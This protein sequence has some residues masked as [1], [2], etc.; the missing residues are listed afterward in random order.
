[1]KKSGSFID[2]SN[3]DTFDLLNNQITI[4]QG[5][6]QFSDL[7]HDGDT[8][9]LQPSNN[10]SKS[11]KFVIEHPQDIAASSSFEINKNLDNVGVGSLSATKKSA[12]NS[13]NLVE[14]SD[15]FNNDLNPATAQSFRS[16]LTAST[17]RQKWKMKLN[18]LSVKSKQARFV[19]SESRIALLPSK[20]LSFDGVDF[21]LNGA[22]QS[23]GKS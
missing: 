19:L 23:I 22:N 13:A 3:G 14:I 4:D 5:V 7:P 10:I 18:S 2:F 12:G 11:L 8:I 20:T 21:T 16:N 1:M 15:I 6:L 17:V 9:Y